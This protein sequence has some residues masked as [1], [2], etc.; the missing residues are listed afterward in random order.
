MKKRS[1]K[2][3]FGDVDITK[4][5]F[6]LYWR[7][8]VYKDDYQLIMVLSIDQNI[9]NMKLFLLVH[10]ISYE[11]AVKD[12]QKEVNFYLFELQNHNPLAYLLHH[13]GQL[14]NVY[15]KVMFVYVDKITTKNLLYYITTKAQQVNAVTCNNASVIVEKYISHYVSNLIDKPFNKYQYE[16]YNV[17]L[18]HFHDLIINKLPEHDNFTLNQFFTIIEFAKWLEKLDIYQFASVLGY[19]KKIRLIKQTDI[20]PFIAVYHHVKKTCRNVERTN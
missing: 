7:D 10:D 17:N 12:I 18:N 6:C 5:H 13:S 9:Y 1:G 2:I 16:N 19:L 11:Q 20:Q 14:A 8:S 15:G 3:S 4:P